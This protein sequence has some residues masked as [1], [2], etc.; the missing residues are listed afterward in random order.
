[1]FAELA[2]IERGSERTS[3][4]VG[5]AGIVATVVR[6]RAVSMV[7]PLLWLAIALSLSGV[8]V[9]GFG[10][11]SDVEAAGMD[12]D[13][14]LRFAWLATA[15]LAGFGILAIIKIFFTPDESPRHRH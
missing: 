7:P 8:I 1:M 15:S 9:F 4:V 11:R 3:W 10:S 12:D 14:F 2:S 5:A 13:V 6:L